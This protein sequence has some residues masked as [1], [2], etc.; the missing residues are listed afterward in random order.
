M[1][2]K[3]GFTIIKNEVINSGISMKALGLFLYLKSKP[4]D[5][6]FSTIRIQ[7]EVK[8]GL[9]SIRECIKELEKANLIQRK[10]TNNKKG[11]FETNYIFLDDEIVAE[12]PPTE[13]IEEPKIEIVKPKERKTVVKKSP[14]KKEDPKP[15]ENLFP[16]PEKPK[17]E[18]P[19][20]P[21]TMNEDG[22]LYARMV[23]IYFDWFKGL[24]GVSPKFG[25]AEGASL[26]QIINYFKTIYKDNHSEGET[27]FEE[28]TKMLQYIF[29]YWHLIDPFLQKQTK[30]TQINSNIQNIINDIKNGHKRKSSNNKDKSEHARGERLQKSFNRI[31]EMLLNKKQN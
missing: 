4:K 21:P 2:E 10:K 26:K 31:D 6:R 8:T 3:K 23:E 19:K 27:E 28:V 20:T 7:N 15:E 24:S 12:N 13:I 5:W 1:L 22:K 17:E 30:V 11:Q 16:E 29:K 18:E 14:P 25:Q 9:H